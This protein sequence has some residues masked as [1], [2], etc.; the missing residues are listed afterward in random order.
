MQVHLPSF[1]HRLGGSLR[2][3]NQWPEGRRRVRCLVCARR[4][5]SRQKDE[6]VC[7]RCRTADPGPA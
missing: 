4:F 5:L 3:S 1:G 7:P 2:P 6:R